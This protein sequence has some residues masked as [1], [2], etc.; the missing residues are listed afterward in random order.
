VAI[1]AGEQHSLALKSDGSIVGWGSNDFGQA[2]RANGLGLRAVVWFQGCTLGCPGCFNPITHDPEGG[3]L[4]NIKELT[5]QI[6][7]SGTRIEVVTILGRE[8]FQQPDALLHLLECLLRLF[9][10]VRQKVRQRAV[11]TGLLTTC[12]WFVNDL[13]PLFFT[14][15]LAISASQ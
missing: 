12:Y 10:R 5:E 2:S 8:P 7:P 3:S 9:V 15:K 13:R 4:A 6:L 11:D 14:Q 1:S